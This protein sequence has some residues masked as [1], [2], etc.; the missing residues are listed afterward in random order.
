M[1]KL[2]IIYIPITCSL[3]TS[4]TIANFKM[5][6]SSLANMYQVFLWDLIFNHNT[7][8]LQPCNKTVAV[9]EGY[10]NLVPPCNLITR[11]L[12]LCNFYTGVHITVY[13]ETNKLQ[14]CF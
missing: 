11:L 4:N 2:P 14:N 8:L 10:Y 1:N 12:Q 13:K 5:Y 9:L 7:R 6:V 3:P